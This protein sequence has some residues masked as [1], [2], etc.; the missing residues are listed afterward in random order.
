VIA[1]V[2]I[3]ALAIL[4]FLSVSDWFRDFGRGRRR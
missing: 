2:L 1:W 3:A 4:G